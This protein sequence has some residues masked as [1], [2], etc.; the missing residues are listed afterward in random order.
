MLNNLIFSSYVILKSNTFVSFTFISIILRSGKVFSISNKFK[1]S[2]ALLLTHLAVAI[3]FV[4]Y[5]KNLI[6]PSDACF[7]DASTTAVDD[8]PLW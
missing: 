6:K 4:L 7:C 2:W 5:F 1:R 8:S 3:A